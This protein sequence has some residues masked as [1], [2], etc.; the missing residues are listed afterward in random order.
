MNNS[1]YGKT[2]ENV[3]NGVDI[4]LVNT[5]Y[6]G[7]KLAAKPNFRDRIIFDKNLAAFHMIKVKVVP[8][9]NKPV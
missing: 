4:C 8:V 7:K 6:K 5:E 9:L 1:V 2:M 3:R